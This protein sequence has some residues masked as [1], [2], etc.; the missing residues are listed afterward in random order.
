MLFVF[1][2]FCACKNATCYLERGKSEVT[3]KCKED[4]IDRDAGCAWATW[5]NGLEG[6]G[7]TGWYQLHVEGTSDRSIAS[8]AEMMRC[9]GAV[10]GYISQSSIWNAFVL[11]LDSHNWNRTEPHYPDGWNEYMETSMQFVRESFTSYTEVPY[12]QAIEMIYHQFEGLAEG[13][14]LALA[15]HNIDNQTMTLIDHWILQSQGDLGDAEHAVGRYAKGPVGPTKSLMDAESGD[16]VTLGDHCTG[17][18]KLTKDY[19]DVYMAHDAWSTYLDLHGALKEYHLPCDKFNAKRVLMSTRAGKLSSYDDFYIAD[20]GLF[21]IETTMSLFNADLYEFVKP[22]TLFTWMRAIHAMWTAHNGSDWTQTFIKHNSGTYNNQYLVLDSNK[23]ERFK[24]PT[25]DLLWVIEQYPGPHWKRAD[26]TEQLVRDLYF[27][28][29]NKPSFKELYEIAGYPE[30]VAA[31]GATGNFYTYETSARYLIIQREAPRLEDFES[32]KAFMRYNNWKR[33]IYSNGDASQQIMSRYDQ[34]RKGDPY[35]AAKMFGGLDS[36]CMRLTEAVTSLEFH[37]I[38]SPS[39]DNNP[40]W[41][42]SGS[43][44]PDV[45]HDGLPDVWNFS[46]IRF[47]SADYTMCGN[48]ETKE[49]CVENSWCGWCMYDQKCMA[50]DKSGPFGDAQCESGWGV[51]TVTPSWAIPVI[52]AVCVIVVLVVGGVLLLHFMKKRK[53]NRDTHAFTTIRSN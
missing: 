24:K 28:S 12:W 15:D 40:V 17:L 39:F 9:A 22:Q 45:R 18:F 29:I 50:G 25:Q 27:P 20:S 19:S 23:F 35:G 2:A 42:F 52:A 3:I 33:D 4:I 37:A 31:S 1:A 49:E 41:N 13:Y 11:L 44:W 26:V 10:E 51:K 36:K 46:W 7:T 8:D 16:P 34:R 48:Y 38:A 5:D 47:K 43:A 32:F 30:K 6:E 21:V 14:N 53:E